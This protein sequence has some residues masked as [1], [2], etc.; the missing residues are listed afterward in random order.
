MSRVED[1]YW[2]RRM[3]DRV[4]D[5]FLDL[6]KRMDKLEKEME[7]LSG[8]VRIDVVTKPFSSAHQTEKKSQ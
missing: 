6:E 2:E 4:W 5:K 1:E 3:K 7:R 8:L